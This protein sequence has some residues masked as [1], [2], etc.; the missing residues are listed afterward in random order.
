FVPERP[1]CP[2]TPLFAPR[3]VRKLADVAI[4][5]ERKCTSAPH[6]Y[7]RRQRSQPRLMPHS[8][9]LSEHPWPTSYRNLQFNHF[10]VK[11]HD[12]LLYHTWLRVHIKEKTVRRLSFYGRKLGGRCLI[13]QCPLSLIPHAPAR[14]TNSRRNSVRSIVRTLLP[15]SN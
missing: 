12:P 5:I 6:Q 3:P 15:F 1:L 9:L 2:D 4:R 10:L 11:D 7:N 14:P 13:A 8:S